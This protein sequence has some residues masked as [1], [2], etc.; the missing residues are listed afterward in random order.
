MVGYTLLLA[1]IEYKTLVLRGDLAGAARVLPQIPA[2][3]RNAVAR[4]LDARDMKAEALAIATDADY[5]FELA[6]AR[7][8]ANPLSK[9]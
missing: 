8:P 4:F 6:G 3:Q 9:P 1:M 5:R 7:T 2:E